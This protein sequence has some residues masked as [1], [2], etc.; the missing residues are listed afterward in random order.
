M[1]FAENLRRM[2]DERGMSQWA[3]GRLINPVCPKSGQSAV[4][5]WCRGRTKPTYDSL[6]DLRAALGCT[7]EELMCDG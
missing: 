2:L 5:S 4:H 3:L 6:I 7:W 1:T